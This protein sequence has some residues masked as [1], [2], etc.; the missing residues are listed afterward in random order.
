ME[1]Q[2]RM[3]QRSKRGSREHLLEGETT[4]IEDKH[5]AEDDE[6]TDEFQEREYSEKDLKLTFK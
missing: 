2:I 3:Q 1:A 5:V 6:L 4:D